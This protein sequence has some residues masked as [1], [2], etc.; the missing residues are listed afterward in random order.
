[1]RHRDAVSLQELL[2]FLD[3]YTRM[4]L[5]ADAVPFASQRARVFLFEKLSFSGSVAQLDCSNASTR[6]WPPPPLR[7]LDFISLLLIKYVPIAGV[8]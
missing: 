7:C 4:H 2:K 3:A 1:L 8:A 5:D 6:R